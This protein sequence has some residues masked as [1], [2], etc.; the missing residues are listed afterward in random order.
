MKIRLDCIECIVRQARMTAERSTADP[1][2]RLRIVTETMRRV[3]AA[4]LVRSPAEHSLAAYA[5]AAELSGVA[6]PF[7][8]SKDEQNAHALAMYDELRDRVARAADGLRTA[9][10]LAVAGNVVDLG[11]GLAFDVRA[12]IEKVLAG[13]LA[14]DDFAAFA[15]EL[16]AARTLLYLCDNCGEIVFDKL[17]IAA[18]RA[19]FPA[20]RVTAVVKGAPIINDATLR[21]ADRVGLAEAA[22]VVSTG[23]ACIGAPLRDIDPRIAERMRA[24]DL[25]VSK[26]Q[27]NFET[28]SDLPRPIYFLLKAKCPCV[29][30]ELGVRF[31]DVVFM[32]HEGQ[33]S[34]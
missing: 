10:K 31:G 30:D 11:I 19:R 34:W 9:A 4:P 6:D 12:E 24:S 16:G 28:A 7:L 2:L 13:E 1:A 3:L 8:A 17:F 27:G 21:E 15:R 33:G 23:C 26:G 20:L 32:R 29:A 14:I 18:M 5:T 22:E 25:V